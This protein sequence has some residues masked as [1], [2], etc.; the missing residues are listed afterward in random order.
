MQTYK[1]RAGMVHLQVVSQNNCLT[2]I[3]R[4]S[5]FSR[6][7]GKFSTP[8]KITSVFYCWERI[9]VF[10]ETGFLILTEADAGIPQKRNLA[11]K[12]NET[13]PLIVKK[14]SCEFIAAADPEALLLSK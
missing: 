2:N 8:L 12:I 1:I 3:S 10:T 11:G 14:I 7:P 6:D 5:P 9:P 4:L 13:F